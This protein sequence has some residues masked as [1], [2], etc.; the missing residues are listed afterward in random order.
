MRLQARRHLAVVT[1]CVLVLSALA[2]SVTNQARAAE[3][4]VDSPVLAIDRTNVR[5]AGI[6]SAGDVAVLTQQP[7]V[8]TSTVEVLHTD[9]SLVSSHVVGGQPMTLNATFAADGFVFWS[10]DTN[11]C[12]VTRLN[13][14]GTGASRTIANRQDAPGCGNESSASAFANTVPGS[15]VPVAFTV[16]TTTPFL[17]RVLLIDAVTLVTKQ[18]ADIVD[19]DSD[20]FTYY[21]I[22]ATNDGGALL[23][24]LQRTTGGHFL[25]NVGAA[26]GISKRLTNTDLPDCS[27]AQGNY[28][29]TTGDSATSPNLLSR[30]SA[31]GLRWQTSGVADGALTGC[32]VSPDGSRLAISGWLIDSATGIQLRKRQVAGSYYPDESCSGGTSVYVCAHTRGATTVDGPVSVWTWNSGGSGNV[33]KLLDWSGSVTNSAAGFYVITEQMTIQGDLPIATNADYQQGRP[34]SQLNFLCFDPPG[35][36]NPSGSSGGVFPLAEDL[37][38]IVG[39]IRVYRRVITGSGQFAGACRGENLILRDLG[40]GTWA[41]F[42]SPTALEAGGFQRTWTV[43]SGFTRSVEMRLAHPHPGGWSHDVILVGFDAGSDAT[44]ACYRAGI[45]TPYEV[46]TAS[47]VGFPRAAI[48]VCSSDDAGE[49]WAVVDGVRSNSVVWGL[50]GGTQPAGSVSLTATPTSQTVGDD[51]SL[52]AVVRDGNGAIVPDEL[53]S[54]RVTSGPDLQWF[55]AVIRTGSDGAATAILHGSG[56]GTDSVVAWVDAD[57]DLVVD[58]GEPRGTAEVAWTAPTVSTGP[59]LIVHGLDAIAPYGGTCPHDWDDAK[60]YLKSHGFADREIYTV[61]YYDKDVV[62]CDR[63]INESTKP[64][65]GEEYDNTPDAHVAGTTGH[66]ANAA[67]EHLAYHLA[68][69]IYNSYSKNNETVAVLAHSMGGLMT[70]YALAEVAARNDAFP[71]Q[72][73]VDNVVTL[74]SPHGGARSGKLAECS[75]VTLAKVD[76]LRECDEMTP[77]SAFLTGLEDDGW[78]PQGARGTDW[79]AI[80]SDGDASVSADRAVGSSRDRQSDLYFGAC[81]KVWY[82]YQKV[83][84]RVGRGGGPSRHEIGHDEYMHDG[85]ITGGMDATDLLAYSSQ[86]H[87]GAPLTAVTAQIHPMALAALALTSSDY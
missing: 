9:G 85:S 32:A 58:T 14:D 74:G 34:T 35:S 49:H 45:A 18:S 23:S 22:A 87:C 66:T 43:E 3:P 41:E 47:T 40:G 54:F 13:L 72:L 51:V 78:D 75:L 38:S 50:T 15:T 81:H 39:D 30:N 6:T 28:F 67:I 64:G 84:T 62:G 80:G 11:D 68:W 25:V 82:R 33:L 48:G 27:D 5:A 21:A 79:T 31:D 56:V 76:H 12:V 73:L 8:A 57:A 17:V 7:N 1:A 2:S 83:D 55:G 37:I 19:P 63:S 70:R 77:G 4:P 24:V 53:V 44:I 59:V 52:R 69:F 16:Q 10:G 71:P 61:G 86:G 26:G 60:Q 29:G 36:T 65:L 42:D 46:V 20:L